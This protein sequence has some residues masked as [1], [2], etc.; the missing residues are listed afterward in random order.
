MVSTRSGRRGCVRLG[1]AGLCWSRSATN[2]TSGS[3]LSLLMKVAETLERLLFVEGARPFALVT[4]DEGPDIALQRLGQSQLVV[5][6]HRAVDAPSRL[7][8]Q[9]EV[10]CSLSAVR[11]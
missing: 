7:P 10:R 5:D 6:D 4:V 3:R 2:W 1:V 9:T 8:S 11:M